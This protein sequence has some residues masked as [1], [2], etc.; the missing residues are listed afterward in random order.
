MNRSYTCRLI[1]FGKGGHR[2]EYAS[3]S[4][5]W[6]GR[7]TLSGYDRPEDWQPRER[8]DYS[9]C[10]VLDTRAA[11]DT[12]AG[13][14]WVFRGPLLNP[15]LPDGGREDCPDPS[16]IAG[17][18]NGFGTLARLQIA[19]T[20]TEKAPG[21]LDQVSR[22]EYVEGWRAVGARVGRVEAGKLVWEA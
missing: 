5:P 18:P 12:E 21:P 7:S 16:F 2:E 19:H 14:R 22:A 4:G 1:S 3:G 15:D 10:V 11:T 8:T 9:D 17:F 6:E 20:A 13:F